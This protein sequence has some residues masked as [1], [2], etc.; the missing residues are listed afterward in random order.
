MRKHGTNKRDR[1]R[2]KKKFGMRM[3]NKGVKRLMEHEEQRHNEAPITPG[4]TRFNCAGDIMI[5]T[6]RSKTS[7]KWY[8]TLDKGGY[9]PTQFAEKFIRKHQVADK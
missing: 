7:N 4:V 8:A 2:N 1:K 5:V 6:K 3:H 9:Y